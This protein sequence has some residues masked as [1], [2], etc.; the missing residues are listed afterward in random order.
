MPK[1][2]N[3]NPGEPIGTAVTDFYDTMYE[4]CPMHDGPVPTHEWDKEQ[5]MCKPCNEY[6]SR[7]EREE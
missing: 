2:T 1:I 5:G 7:L 3:L 4:H 6:I